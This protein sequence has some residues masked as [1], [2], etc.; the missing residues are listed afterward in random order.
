MSK[1]TENTDEPVL[2]C[3]ICLKEIPKSLAINEEA[4]TYVYHF[5]GDN[6]YQQ[7]EKAGKPELPDNKD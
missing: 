6:C 4:K 2:Q 3:S 5:C 7:W 1:D